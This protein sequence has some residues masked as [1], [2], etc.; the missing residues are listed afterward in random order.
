[1]KYLLF[2]GCSI[3]QKENAYELSARKVADKLGIELVDFEE[4]NCCGFFLEAV[5]HLSAQ[6]LAARDLSLAE[7]AGLDVVTLCT[8]CFGHLTKTRAHLLEDAGLRD[9]VN[10]ILKK[11]GREFKGSSEV[12]HF[13][14]VLLEDVGVEKIMETITTPLD[15][16][17]VVSHWGCHILKPSDQLNID[18][19]E[20]PE[21]LN[22][23][24]RLTKAEYVHYMEEKL[25]CGGPVSGVD[26]KLSLKILRE[27]LASVQKV[28]ADAIITVCPFCHIHFDLNQL[29][30]EEEFSEVYEIPVLHYTQLLGL[31]QGISP[32]DLGSYENRTPVDDLLEKL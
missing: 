10:D 18:D 25:C 8:G 28:N 20:N 16:L 9:E 21:Q 4:A 27:K 7:Q 30:I 26:E 23:L 19:P 3:P 13:M 5:D 32:D 1:M 24:I 11:G 12:K 22:S 2:S 14:Q 31:A 29:S 17:R 15:K 6:V